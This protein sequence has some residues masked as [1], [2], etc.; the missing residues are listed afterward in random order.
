MFSGC[1]YS[2]SGYI[3]LFWTNTCLDRIVTLLE[4]NIVLLILININGEKQE[5]TQFDS[6]NI[7]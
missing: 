5:M 6:L 3:H 1:T 4:T 7:N 2:A